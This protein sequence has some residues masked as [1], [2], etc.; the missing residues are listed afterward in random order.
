[1]LC[2]FYYPGTEASLL[3][4]IHSITMDKTPG[5]RRQLIAAALIY[6]LGGAVMAYA[7]ELGVLLAG[8][9]L[10]GLG[11]GLVGYFKP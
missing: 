2:L 5:R 10:Y 9:L 7:P 3:F 11:I 4:L 6:L 8:R 1:M